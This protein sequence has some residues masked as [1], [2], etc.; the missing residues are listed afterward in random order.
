MVFRFRTWL[1]VMLTAFASIMIVTAQG[2]A[3]LFDD[4]EDGPLFSGTDPNG[5]GIGFVPFK[6]DTSDP[7]TL[8]IETIERD[9]ANT[10]ALKIEYDHSV[11]GGFTHGF[12]DETNWVSQDWTPFD[13]L[14]FWL[15]G[16]ST[17]GTV[18]VDIFDNRVPDNP[19]D[20]AERFFFNITDDY[21]GWQQ[22]TI[23]FAQFQRRTDFQPLG[24]PDDGLGLNPVWG[25]AFDF[26]AG[27]GMQTAYLDNVTVVNIDPIVIEGFEAEVLDQ[28]NEDEFGNDLGFITFFGQPSDQPTLRLIDANRD[29]QASGSLVVD[30]DIQGFGGFTYIY[31]N[32]TERTPQDWTGYN[33]IRFWFYGS[34]SGEDIQFEIFDNLNPNQPGDTAERWFYRFPDDQYGWQQIEIPF[35]DF[36]RRG[37][38]QPQGALNDGFNLNAVTGYAFNLP[39]GSGNE[40]LVLDELELLWADGVGQPEGV[41]GG[42]DDGEL[43]TVEIDDSITWESRINDFELVW[44]DEFNLPAGSPIDPASWTCEVGGWGW[45][46]NEHQYYTTSTDNAAHDGNGS[47][48]ITA[49]EEDFVAEDPEED[50]SYND[51]VC[52]YT[53][54]R[55]ITEGKVEYLHGRVEMRAKIPTGQGIWPAF[56]ML[57]DDFREVGWPQTGEIDIMENVGGRPLEITG[58]IHG[59][60]YAGGASIGRKLIG[61]E[62][63]TNDFHVY[64]IDWDPFVIRFYVDGELYGIISINDLFTTNEEDWVFEHPFFLLINIAVGGNYPGYPDETTVFPQE[65]VIDYIRWYQLSN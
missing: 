47:L 22:F 10:Q 24:A 29:E 62:P 31:N 63:W 6:D 53:S 19:A 41:L 26:P 20:T 43:I 58:T 25:Y 35:L 14:Q 9:G 64:A 51:G 48:V 16:N 18:R 56:W 34:A 3:P 33:S 13:A 49:I 39:I 59:P 30:Y 1:L 42:P 5:I 2:D 61:D 37:D 45:G 7:P 4:F 36:Q 12:T 17:E 15:Y 46:N 60:G 54:A 65:Y 38:F 44:S 21:T 57:G 8:S 32:G 40:A 52:R 23:P 55:C 11:F 28:G 27:V 50:C